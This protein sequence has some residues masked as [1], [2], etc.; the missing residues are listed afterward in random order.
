MSTEQETLRK[1]WLSGQQGNLCAREQAKAW[2]LREAWNE[3]E[4]STHGMLGFI[5]QRVTKVD[6]SSVTTPAVHQLLARIDS[7]ESWFPGKCT[8]FGTARRA[9]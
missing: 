7:D 4:G 6:G 1:L 8:G 5:V 2:A 3:F 9:L